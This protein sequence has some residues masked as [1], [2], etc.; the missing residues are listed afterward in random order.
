[1]WNGALSIEAEPSADAILGSGKT[2]LDYE[3]VFDNFGSMDASVVATFTLPSEF[4]YV[5]GDVSTSGIVPYPATVVWTGV[6]SAG[7][8]TTVTIH[9]R[10]TP[11]AGQSETLVAY[12]DV[13]DGI[14]PVVW[15]KTF[16]TYLNPYNLF[17]PVVSRNY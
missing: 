7:E 6:I 17:M 16:V 8:T 14:N 4:E 3:A 13:D 9:G 10:V 2:D 5:S 12:L 1:M 11:D 15:R